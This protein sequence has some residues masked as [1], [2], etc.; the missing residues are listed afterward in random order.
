MVGP[1]RVARLMVNLATRIAPG[2]QLDPVRVNGQFGWYATV[3]GRPEM[4]LVPSFRGGRVCEVLA[5][6]NPE[7][8]AH[9][10]AAWEA[11]R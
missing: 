1:D 6:L 11:A 2:T 5:V 3:D 8:L 9:F 10:H 4:V 7:K